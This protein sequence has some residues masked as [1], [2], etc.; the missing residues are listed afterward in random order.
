MATAKP[1]P[2]EHE[3]QSPRP[4]P[5]D[6]R[7]ELEQLGLNP[8]QARLLLAL[9][10]LGPA[11][12]PDLARVSGVPRTSIYPVLEELSSKSL[13]ERVSG[14]G[15]AVWAAPG[16]DEILDRLHQ[17]EQER[18]REHESRTERVRRLLAESFPDAPSVS[19]THAHVIKGMAQV[20]RAYERMLSETEHELVMFTRP[21]YTWATGR[22]NPAVLAMLERGVKARVLY[23]ATQWEDPT[24]EAFRQEAEVYHSAGVVPRL[25]DE[26]PIKL[27]V[28]DRR[29]AL[30][31]MTLE[32]V[33]EDGYPLTLWI[34]H[35]GYAA[36]HAD[37]FE[38]RWAA[39]RPLGPPAVGASGR[40]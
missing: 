21:P 23:Q 4:I 22:P 9:L 20:R 1:E 32:A 29:M 5:D 38:Q 17:A 19:L 37:A 6:V 14:P 11:K 3:Q 7:S 27:V 39:A 33:A 30:V 28:A 31:A 24:A 16:R 18:L 12:A 40:G 15:P 26:L 2:A 25:A 34:E 8:N 36:I 35:A 10:R 13:A